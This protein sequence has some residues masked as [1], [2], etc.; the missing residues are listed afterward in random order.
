MTN[1][2]RINVL[3]EPYKLVLK[4][5]IVSS[6]SNPDGTVG[7]MAIYDL[8]FLHN[9]NRHQ[10]LNEISRLLNNELPQ[11]VEDFKVSKTPSLKRTKKKKIDVKELKGNN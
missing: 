8:M 2:E 1:E 3:L 7:M 5:G 4:N 6:S 10:A 11:I 9:M